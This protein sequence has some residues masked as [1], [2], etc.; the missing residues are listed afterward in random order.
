[1]HGVV[2]DCAACHLS[3]HHNGY[4][5]EMSDAKGRSDAVSQAL[6]FLS[7]GGAQSKIVSFNVI[8]H[9]WEEA[10]VV[11]MPKVS[12]ADGLYQVQ[13]PHHHRGLKAVVDNSK[14]V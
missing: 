9:L 13:I 3:T 12:D 7:V 6:P 14:S 11:K 4:F 5:L 10:H 1:M 2:R 8:Q